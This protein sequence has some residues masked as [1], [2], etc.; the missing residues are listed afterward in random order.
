MQINNCSSQ[1]IF[2]VGSNNF[3]AARN[4]IT[5]KKFGIF[6]LE[7]FSNQLGREQRGEGGC[8]PE[9]NQISKYFTILEFT[10]SN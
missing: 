6:L 1:Q 8:H 3:A 9:L 2:N 10:S 7:V 5:V 4:K